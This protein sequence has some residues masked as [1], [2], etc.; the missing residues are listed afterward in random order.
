MINAIKKYLEDEFLYSL[1]KKEF[2]EFCS[3]GSI[4]ELDNLYDILKEKKLWLHLTWLN[5]YYDTMD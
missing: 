4:E 5:N 2:E 1:T 3:K